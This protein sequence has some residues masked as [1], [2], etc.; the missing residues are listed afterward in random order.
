MNKTQLAQALGISASMVSRLAKRGMPT[1]S[2]EAA[3]RWRRRHL[4]PG[5]TKG[6]RADQ[7]FS[8]PAAGGS[9]RSGGHVSTVPAMLPS[10]DASDLSRQAEILI[11]EAMQRVQDLGALAHDA[12]LTPSAFDQLAPLLR[13]AMQRV[14]AFAR[15]RV[16][17]S[18]GVWDALTSAVSLCAL[19]GTNSE[20]GVDPDD[21]FM[22]E[23]WYQIALGPD[24]T[25]HHLTRRPAPEA[26][27]E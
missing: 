24:L 20:R 10:P 21:E 22:A 15:D 23:F 4:E 14:P 11:D 7:L 2:V 19:S 27:K 8:A 26:C 6:Q 18:E 13:A 12:L 9:A 1:A 5:R 17:L 16:R 3:Q 25:D